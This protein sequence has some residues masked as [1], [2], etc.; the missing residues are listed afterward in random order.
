MMTTAFVEKSQQST[1]END[2]TEEGRRRIGEGNRRCWIVEG[3][4]GW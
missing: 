2:Y 1:D 4:E 3:E